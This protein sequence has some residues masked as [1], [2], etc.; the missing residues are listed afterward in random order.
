MDHFCKMS[1]K[2]PEMSTN[3][4]WVHLVHG[5]G[6]HLR[7]SSVG[8]EQP[9]SFC[10]KLWMT[11]KLRIWIQY[12]TKN[13]SSGTASNPLLSKN[14]TAFLIIGWGHPK[15]TERN[16]PFADCIIPLQNTL[17]QNVRR[18]LERI[19]Q[20][21]RAQA[22]QCERIH[23]QYELLAVKQKKGEVS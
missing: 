13:T 4:H 15:Q 16:N 10:P 2:Y 1:L 3:A 17:L 21:Q 9:L 7:N 14:Q 23:R 19:R 6:V 18:S 20:I 5:F 12:L 11:Q 8:V 22:R